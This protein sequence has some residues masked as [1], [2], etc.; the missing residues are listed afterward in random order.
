MRLEPLRRERVEQGHCSTHK[1]RQGRFCFILNGGF[2]LQW[3][4]IVVNKAAF[5]ELTGRLVYTKLQLDIVFEPLL[6]RA[7][8]LS[9]LIVW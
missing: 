5:G 1:V 4:V 3:A 2:P 7:L 8:P 9:N 6:A